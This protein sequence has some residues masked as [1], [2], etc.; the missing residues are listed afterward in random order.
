MNYL[1]AFLTGN[2][3]APKEL[4]ALLLAEVGAALEEHFTA[5]PKPDPIDDPESE[6]DE[7]CDVAEE[8]L[9]LYTDRT[10]TTG[11]DREDVVM[12]IVDLLHLLDDI[13]LD[14]GQIAVSGGQILLNAH[15]QYDL[16]TR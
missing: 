7:R 5:N 14:Q 11:T 12:L 10:G 6:L 15:R 1:P 3:V 9:D 2:R 8:I 16:E 13:Q 4:D